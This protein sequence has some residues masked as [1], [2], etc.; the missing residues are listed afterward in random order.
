MAGLC[1]YDKQLVRVP[2]PIDMEELD[3]KNIISPTSME[4]TVLCPLCANVALLEGQR[5][6]EFCLTL[7]SKGLLLSISVVIKRLG[8]EIT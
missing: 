2:G 6:W 7:K 1:D 4:K 3:I 5:I 8:L